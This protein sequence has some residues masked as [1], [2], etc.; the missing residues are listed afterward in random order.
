M[1]PAYVAHC[2]EGR[3]RLRHP[4]LGDAA[5]REAARAQL[6]KEEGV[7]EVRPGAESLLV[8]LRPGVDVFEL[9]RR[10]ER[11]LP[12]LG[13][14]LAEV[15]AERRAARRALRREQPRGGKAISPAA[16]SAV[17]RGGRGDRR[18]I[19]GISERK[20]ELRALLGVAGLC[21]AAGFAGP[22]RLHLVAG[23]VW[24]LLAGRHVWVRRK[25]L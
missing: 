7:L 8:L 25:A 12:V 16:S 13:R 6:Q 22:K 15:A 14:P 4:A 3:A 18:N 21:L 10:L 23:A 5:V 17:V 2:M 1:Y 24:A 20:L 11:H 9:C 19:L